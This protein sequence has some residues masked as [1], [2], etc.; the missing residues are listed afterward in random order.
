LNSTSH[1]GLPPVFAIPCSAQG[2]HHLEQRAVQA[3]KSLQMYAI[4]SGSQRKTWPS[5]RQTQSEDSKRGSR[6]KLIQLQLH[7]VPQP[8]WLVLGDSWLGAR[9]GLANMTPIVKCKSA[10]IPNEMLPIATLQAHP[11]LQGGDS[12]IL[13]NL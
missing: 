13:G 5:Y 11:Q 8:E 4:D 10:K 2:Q 3:M 12:K 6:Q 1:L 9:T 7:S